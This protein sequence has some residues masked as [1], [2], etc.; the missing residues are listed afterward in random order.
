M[1]KSTHRGHKVSQDYLRIGY[2]TAKKTRK[3]VY[4]F[5]ASGIVK[6]VRAKI[7]SDAAMYIGACLEETNY[8]PF[9]FTD[10]CLELALGYDLKRDIIRELKSHRIVIPANSDMLDMYI[11]NRD[12][13]VSL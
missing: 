7:S 3:R 11:I 10:V 9:A 8:L 5:T 4:K 12:P 6:L 2:T 13:P 1:V